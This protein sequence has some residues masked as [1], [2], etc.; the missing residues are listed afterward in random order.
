MHISKLNKADQKQILSSLNSAAF[1]PPHASVAVPN[2]SLALHCLHSN[3]YVGEINHANVKNDFV[4]PV[5]DS[6]LSPALAKYTYS[7]NSNSNE[8]VIS[9]LIS[10]MSSVQNIQHATAHL[11]LTVADISI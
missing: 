7:L 11:L 6:V 2:G 4:A 1:C 9:S 3:F 8:S 5:I 10:A